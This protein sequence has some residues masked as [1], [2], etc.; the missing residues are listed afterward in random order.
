MFFPILIIV[1]GII[2]LLNNL[3]I[4]STSVWSIIMPVAVILAGISMV[5]GKKC[6]WCDWHKDDKN[7][8]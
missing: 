1:V 5:S 3:N 6:S 4:I 2:W 7:N 8:K